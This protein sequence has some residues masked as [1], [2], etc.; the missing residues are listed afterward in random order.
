MPKKLKKPKK[1]TLLSLI[2]GYCHYDILLKV[3]GK[4]EKI[5]RA[6]LRDIL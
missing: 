1:K 5:L 4:N 2:F 6:R 3:P